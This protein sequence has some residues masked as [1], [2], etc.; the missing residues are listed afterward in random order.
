M[1]PA[2]TLLAN[3]AVDDRHRI[4]NGQRFTPV[5][6]AFD[7]LDDARQKRDEYREPEKREKRHHPDFV[8]ER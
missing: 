8:L 1:P 4:Q 2:P 3:S 7:S 6:V 5:P